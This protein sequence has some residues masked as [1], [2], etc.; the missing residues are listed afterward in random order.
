MLF[1]SIL[2]TADP[3]VNS[4]HQWFPSLHIEA[5]PLW[6]WQLTQEITI[7]LILPHFKMRGLDR[8]PGSSLSVLV[9]NDAQEDHLPSRLGV[10]SSH[11]Q[12]STPPIISLERPACSQP[13]LLVRR[14]LTPARNCSV[15]QPPRSLR[16]SSCCH[17]CVWP[18]LPSVSLQK[19]EVRRTSG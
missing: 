12:D 18:P 10:G 2:R 16:I 4:T 17:S 7:F 1:R 6:N 9:L 5:L 8:G 3:T 13:L 19:Q 14:K 11:L 15:I